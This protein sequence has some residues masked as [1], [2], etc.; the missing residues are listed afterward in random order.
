MAFLKNSGKQNKI[1]CLPLG[2]LIFVSKAWVGNFNILVKQKILFVNEKKWNKILLKLK[3]KDWEIFLLNT[4][5]FSYK[6]LTKFA[7]LLSIF[8]GMNES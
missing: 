4:L 8:H 3:A 1:E 6:F 7:Q 2:S 5:N